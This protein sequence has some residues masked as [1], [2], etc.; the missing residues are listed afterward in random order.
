MGHRKSRRFLLWQWKRYPAFPPDY[1]PNKTELKASSGDQALPS[2]FRGKKEKHLNNIIPYS[3]Q[4]GFLITTLWTE[5]EDV[6][7]EEEEEHE[8][9]EEEEGKE[10]EEEQEEEKK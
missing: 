4:I 1:E 9:E 2:E 6:E 5:G 3:N 7:E 10:K 8:E